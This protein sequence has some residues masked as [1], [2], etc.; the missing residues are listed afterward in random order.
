MRA[1]E[2]HGLSKEIA[3]AAA[4]IRHEDD[5]ARLQGT[6]VCNCDP[7]VLL[8]SRTLPGERRRR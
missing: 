8:S 5:C 1:A 7:D 2:E 6:G 4:E 3:V